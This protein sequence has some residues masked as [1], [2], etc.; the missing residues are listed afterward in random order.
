[1]SAS[2]RPVADGVS[3]WLDAMPNPSRAN[4]GVIHD[5]D[6]ITL[7]DSL[8]APSA[9]SELADALNATDVPLRRLVYTGAT[10]TQVG[11]SS[12]FPLAAV[13]GSAQISAELELSANPDGLRR[14]HP[15]F[16]AEFDDLAVRGVT[17]VVGEPAWVS[18]TAIAVPV[19]GPLPG[20]LAVQV[21]AA[22]VVFAGSVCSFGVVPLGFSAD[23]AA[24]ASG[25]DRLLEL[26]SIIVP[27]IGPVGGEREL[28]V[29]RDYLLACCHAGGDLAGLPAGPWIDWP[30]HE[31]HAVNVERAAIVA[32]GRD[33]IPSS[34]LR[35]L[36]L[37]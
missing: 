30:G 8:V 4:A 2:L 14:L 28:S 12:V 34:M 29:L 33:E 35:L 7:V 20:N 3:V 11:G 32:A 23:L 6:G 24:W 27:G 1:M 19:E 13:Y 25:L 36:G 10:T 18:A 26:G 16:A 22:G 21:P 5:A 31:L 17:H 37:G 15:E 9:A